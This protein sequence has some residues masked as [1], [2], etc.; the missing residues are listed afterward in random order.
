MG[1]GLQFT[2]CVCKRF[3]ASEDKIIRV[4][5]FFSQ[6][7]GFS[8]Q[9]K[10]SGFFEFS[11]SMDPENHIEISAAD[12]G[13]GVRMGIVEGASRPICGTMEIGAYP[14]SLPGAAPGLSSSPGSLRS[15]NRASIRMYLPV[16]NEPRDV[17][18]KTYP[19]EAI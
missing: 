8:Q 18:H 7:I 13:N 1:F 19:E 16:L 17:P 15:A 10:E 6:R 11:T 9:L 14:G 4:S 12:H 3:L 2:S 5:D